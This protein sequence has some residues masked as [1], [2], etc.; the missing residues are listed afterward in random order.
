MTLL[1]QRGYG[2]SLHFKSLALDFPKD[3]ASGGAVCVQRAGRCLLNASVA[4]S[5]GGDPVKLLAN[6][7]GFPARAKRNAAGRQAAPR[8]GIS[9]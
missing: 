3:L 2:T 9:L 4:L 8:N 7:S 6:Q 1:G 5:F